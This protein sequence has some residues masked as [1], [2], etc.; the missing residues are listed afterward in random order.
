MLVEGLFESYFLW[1]SLV[2]KIILFQYFDGGRRHLCVN[3]WIFLWTD[4]KY[5]QSFL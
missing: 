4:T 3:N 5:I 2:M 1:N